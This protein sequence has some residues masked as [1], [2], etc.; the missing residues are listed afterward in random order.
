MV[1]LTWLSG[2]V[3][4][5]GAAGCFR[6]HGREAEGDAGPGRDAGSRPDAARIDAPSLDAGASECGADPGVIV[7]LEC[8]ESVPRGAP[9]AVS[10]RAH[11][12]G[13]CAVSAP[14]GTTA[15]ALAPD[16]WEIEAPYS[17]CRCCEMCMCEEV[18]TTRAVT[19]EPPAGPVVRVVAGELACEI[20]VLDDECRT[21]R[22]D[23]WMAPRHV[24]VGEPIAVRVVH[25]RGVS[26]GCAPR[27]E[28]GSPAGPELA[29]LACG[30]SDVDPC[31]DPGYEATAL[32]EGP[33]SPMQAQFYHPYPGG[34]VVVDVH[35]RASCIA[36]ATL[37]VDSLTQVAPDPS[38]LAEDPRATWVELRG[39]HDRCCGEPALLVEEDVVP[40]LGRALSLRDCSPDPC[41]CAIPHRVD[42]VEHHFLGSLPPG[43]TNVYAG[44]RTLTISV[45]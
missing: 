14:A 17:V 10:V 45:P 31:V 3:L 21:L 36:D 20:R 1:L 7:G 32:A 43:T 37:V 33:S 12:L 11:M 27:A 38:L 41:D 2:G 6:S 26:C 29:F 23:T 16:T 25:D 4:A 5:L 44:S 28:L 35:D 19:L 24:A 13:C 34:R 22:A 15:R 30:C 9:I 8:P 39:H 40:G 18:T 42:F